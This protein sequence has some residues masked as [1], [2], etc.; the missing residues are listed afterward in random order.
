[1]RTQPTPPLHLSVATERRPHGVIA[2][3]LRLTA[4]TADGGY[5]N[6]LRPTFVIR[7]GGGVE[8]RVDARQVAPGAYEAEV[9]LDEATAYT[10]ATEG[11][12]E[13]VPA[14]ALMIAANY[15]DEYRFRPVDVRGLS[16]MSIATGGRYEPDA[17]MLAPGGDDAST[18]PRR[19]WP[20]LLVMALAAYV[21]DLLF[22]RVRIFERE[23]F[24]V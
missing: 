2:A 15:P 7:T 16:M 8:R 23:E 20:M 21:I 13:G 14:P 12:Q 17:S 6:L 5:Q 19:L 4:R 18:V 1:V 22:R 3:T 24:A 11:L 10:V 9:T